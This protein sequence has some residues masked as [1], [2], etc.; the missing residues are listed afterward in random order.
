MVVCLCL[1]FGW[2]NVLV[3][4]RLLKGCFQPVS[5]WLKV[6]AWINACWKVVFNRYPTGLKLIGPW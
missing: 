2:I 1:G 5:N 4:Q 3:L 6:D